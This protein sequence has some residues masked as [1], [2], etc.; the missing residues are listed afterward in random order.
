MEFISSMNWENIKSIL[1]T[2]SLNEDTISKLK[3]INTT[4]Y[5]L[6]IEPIKFLSSIGINNQHEQNSIL[7]SI[8]TLY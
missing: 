6:C 4:G 8:F 7:K 5:D 2:E 3:S 1:N